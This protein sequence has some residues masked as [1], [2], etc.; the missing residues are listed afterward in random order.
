MMRLATIEDEGA[1][2]AFLAPFTETS[3]FLRGNL[4]ASGAEDRET[5]HGTRFYLWFDGGGI[6][7]VFGITNH[8]YMMVQ[9]PDAPP[10]AYQAFA[11]ALAGCTVKGITGDVDQAARVLSALR[12]TRGKFSLNQNEPLYRLDLAI[13]P[14]EAFPC[15]AVRETDVATLTH[16]FAHYELDT[17]LAADEETARAHARVRA[18]AAVGSRV[19]L[20]EDNGEPVA[21]AGIN[22]IVGGFVQVG[23]VFVPRDKR[24]RKYGQAVTTALLQV[25]RD[26]GHKTA[27]LF[28][29]NAVAA[30]AYEAVGFEHIGA[31]RIAI[32]DKPLTLGVAA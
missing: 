7:G 23:G 12:L 26:Q 32:F 31:Y 30:K 21:M 4:K 9:A 8:G 13:L 18:A 15:R 29:N 16:W 27:I 5:P 24:G 25:A 10:A 19:R 28:A 6:S 1:I 17:G 22:A 11:D 14:S 3:M 20:I 2:D